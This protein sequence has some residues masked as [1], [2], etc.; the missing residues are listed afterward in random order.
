[1]RQKTQE[2][3]GIR[4]CLWQIKACRAQLDGKHVISIS[5]TGSGKSLSFFMPFLWRPK[6]V[7]ILV[8]PLQLLG[9]QHASESTLEK[10]GIKTVNIT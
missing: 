1:I 3:F 5:P 2:I 6:G 10:L 8:A 9:E 7:K 4:P